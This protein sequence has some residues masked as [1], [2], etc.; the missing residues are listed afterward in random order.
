MRLFALILAL[1]IL[2]AIVLLAVGGMRSRI[3]VSLCYIAAAIA[4]LGVCIVAGQAFPA[5][6]DI[7]RLAGHALSTTILVAGFF[8]MKK[9]AASREGSTF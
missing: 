4:A 7:L 9:S 6:G 5:L 2:I 8:A 1:E 3:T